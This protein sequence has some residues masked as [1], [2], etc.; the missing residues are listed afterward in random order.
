MV[1]KNIAGGGG[2]GRL[3]HAGTNPIRW[4]M[5]GGGGGGTVWSLPM[6]G[7]MNAGEVASKIAVGKCEENI[8]MRE[9]SP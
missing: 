1:T 8:S 6:M 7:G 4:V 5:G 2:G 3:V 9:L